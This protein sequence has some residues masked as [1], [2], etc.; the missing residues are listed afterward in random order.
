MDSNLI[1]SLYPDPVKEGRKLNYSIHIVDKKGYYPDDLEVL[2]NKI[3]N[4]ETTVDR[5]NAIDGFYALISKKKNKIINT[6]EIINQREKVNLRPLYVIFNSTRGLLHD[7]NDNIITI[8]GPLAGG[9]LVLDHEL[10]NLIPHRQLCFLEFDEKHVGREFDF[11][12]VK[13][14]KGE[15]FIC[16]TAKTC[17]TVQGDAILHLEEFP[18]IVDTLKYQLMR[19][20]NYFSKEYDKISMLNDFSPLVDSS[21]VA[22]QAMLAANL[23]SFNNFPEILRQKI[24]QYSVEEHKLPDF[25]CIQKYN[26]YHKTR[27][28]F[29]GFTFV[30]ENIV[31]SLANGALFDGLKYLLIAESDILTLNRYI[32]VLKSDNE[33]RRHIQEYEDTIQGYGR[34]MNNQTFEG[35]LS[36]TIRSRIG[37]KTLHLTL[38]KK[39]DYYHKIPLGI[40]KYIYDPTGHKIL[41][42][43]FDDSE[44]PIEFISVLET[45]KNIAELITNGSLKLFNFN[46]DL[47]NIHIKAS[48]LNFVISFKLN[49]DFRDMY[50]GLISIEL[51]SI[52]ELRDLFHIRARNIPQWIDGF[53]ENFDL[54]NFF[55]EIDKILSEFGLVMAPSMRFLEFSETDISRITSD[56]FPLSAFTQRILADHVVSVLLKRIVRE[57]EEYES[58]AEFQNIRANFQEQEIY[59]N[60]RFEVNKTK[61]ELMLEKSGKTTTRSIEDQVKLEHIEKEMNWYNEDLYS[62]IMNALRR[63]EYETLGAELSTYAKIKYIFEDIKIALVDFGLNPVQWVNA[64]NIQLITSYQSQ[65]LW[66]KNSFANELNQ[67]KNG[68]E[69]DLKPLLEYKHSINLVYNTFFGNITGSEYV[70]LKKAFLYFNPKFKKFRSELGLVSSSIELIKIIENLEN[71]SRL[72]VFVKLP[73]LPTRGKH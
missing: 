62:F 31:Y 12:V 11:C 4:S 72:Q 27:I 53:L 35:R 28:E 59:L 61:L 36:E 1:F 8:G 34:T 67:F 7:K 48:K 39:R 33:L 57:I 32:E 70:N 30:S 3:R 71:R 10:K 64:S 55:C 5:E 6:L 23:T 46:V 15:E 44:L 40:F 68:K 18:L 69:L 25:L 37:R 58:K 63:G 54:T 50:E 60:T 65:I 29:V 21:M 14:E 26:Q 66:I 19:V 17:E 38:D 9:N 51:T 16:D 73:K 45:F 49:P 52:D 42:T 47:F 56:K 20:N 43:S 41:L 24:E 13:T 2:V 22:S